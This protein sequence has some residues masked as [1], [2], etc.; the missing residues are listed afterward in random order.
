MKFALRRFFSL[1]VVFAMIASMSSFGQ[2]FEPIGGPY[3]NDENTLLLLHFD[4]DFTNESDFSADAEVHTNSPQGYE[5]QPNGE[6]G[7]CIYLKNDAISDSSWIS[8]ADT[9]TLDLTGSWTIEGWMNV[10]TFGEQGGDHRW[11]PRLT[12][13][14][15]DEVFWRPNWWVELWGDNRWFQTGFHTADFNNWPAVTSAPN[16]MAP[17]AWVHL[18]FIRDDERKLIVQ[19]VHNAERE[20]V[21]FGTM[22]YANLPDQTPVNTDKPV[23]LGFAGGGADSWLHGFLDEVRIS[24]VIRNFAVPPAI[25]GV[26]ALANMDASVTEYPVEATMFPFK[27]DGSIASALVH[28]SVDGGETWSEVAMTNTEGDTFVGVIPQQPSGSVIQYYVTA[29][30]N[31]GLT[32]QSPGEG[33]PYLQFGIF[34]PNI[35]IL[36]LDFEDALTDGSE[37]DQT[38]EIFNMDAVY[39]DDAKVGSKSLE[40]PDFDPTVEEPGYLTVESPFLTAQEFAVDFWFKH[41]G[42]Q[43]DGVDTLLEYARILI[44]P[45]TAGSHV[46]QNYFVRIE[47]NG[48]IR[49]MYVVE[50]TAETKT[51]DGVTLDIKADEPVIQLGEW[52]HVLY[53][54]STEACVFE[55]R[56]ANDNIIGRVSDTEEI[57]LNPPRN[58]NAPFRLGWAGNSW[59][60]MFRG[61]SGNV[62]GVKVYNYAALGLDTTTVVV[63]VDDFNYDAQVPE[64]YTLKQN[65]PNPFNPTTTIEFAIPEAAEIDLAVYNILGKRVNTLVDGYKEAGSYKVQW[66]GMNASGQKLAT[67]VYF[68]TLKAGKHSQTM[69]MIMLR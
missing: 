68:Y 41:N 16:V 65:Y 29:E 31:N 66:N 56:D 42:Q 45:A 14:T 54:R 51:K 13:K 17:G 34:T 1:A 4:G 63:S 9:S 20:L 5:F 12:I 44:R 33:N 10:F 57:G 22:S 39:S 2:D 18:T 53:E 46:D 60:G 7:Q 48:G 43:V 69:K 58:A 49:A 61:L 30:D 23:A 52:Y 47:P 8:V 24:N 21:W 37:Y 64:S 28:Y 35:Q 38:A 67:G 62:D 32:S 11:V 36:D 40:F 6:L 19:M 15:G 27:A 25:T 59:D 26:E 50:P 3:E 55:L